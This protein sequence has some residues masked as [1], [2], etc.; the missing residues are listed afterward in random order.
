MSKRNDLRFSVVIISLVLSRPVL[1]QEQD[2]NNLGSFGDW[3]AYAYVDEVGKVCYLAGKPKK[4]ESDQ[5]RRGDVFLMVTHRPGV[6]NEISALVGYSVKSNSKVILAVDDQKFDLFS[7]DDTAW[8]KDP[9]ADAS[10]IAA[11][12]KG[13]AVTI[14]ATPVRGTATKDS[15]SLVGF[16][17]AYKAINDSCG[18][19]G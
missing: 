14:D 2:I 7:E 11:M 10:I 6:T 8:A 3:R 12:N 19:K 1:A 13:T 18:I 9:K 15:F 17:K 5:R 4:S 16:A